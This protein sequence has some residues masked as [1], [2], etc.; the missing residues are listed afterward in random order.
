MAFQKQRMGALSVLTKH[1][2]CDICLP[3][4]KCEGWVEKVANLKTPTGNDTEQAEP[5]SAF[6]IP[7]WFICKKHWK[8]SYMITNIHRV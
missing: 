5:K 3:V 8:K 1:E 6:N 4:C 7:D 2:C